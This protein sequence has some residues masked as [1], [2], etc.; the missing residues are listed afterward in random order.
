MSKTK[1]LAQ[2]KRLAKKKKQTKWA[3][4]WAVPKALGKSKL[5]KVHPSAITKV[6][7]RWNR[8]K[9]KL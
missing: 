9:I 5:G 2:K 4:I 1:S 7:R 6:K 8:T 3:P